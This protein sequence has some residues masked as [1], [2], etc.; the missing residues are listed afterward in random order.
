MKQRIIT[1]LIAIPA[2]LWLVVW[3]PYY[4][5]GFVCAVAAA[6]TA[7]EYF[8]FRGHRGMFSL[9]GIFLFVFIL[10]FSV[11]L[12]FAVFVLLAF[13]AIGLRLLRGDDLENYL[14]TSA[15]YGFAF[16]YFGLGYGA[17]ILIRAEGYELLLAMMLAVW[18]ADTFAYFG[19]KLLGKHPMSP[20]ISPNKTW[21]GFAFGVAGATIVYAVTLAFY[22]VSFAVHPAFIGLAVGL[23]SIVGDLVES[24]LKR[25]AGV[26]DSGTIIAGHG[27]IFDR[28]DSMVY[29][30]PLYL[31]VLYT[32]LHL[33]AV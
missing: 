2:V 1:A 3:S 15:Q 33:G 17:M 7:S 8:A 6:L 5:F 18:A 27:G 30:A 13:S 21:E 25:S 31:V 16:L 23:V 10:S 32:L 9:L 14:S 4:V 29:V 19:G 11:H 12:A 20:A 24:A 28:M 26:K 22:P